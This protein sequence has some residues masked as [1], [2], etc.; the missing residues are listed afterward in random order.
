MNEKKFKFG[1]KVMWEGNIY[2][3]LGITGLASSKVVLLNA[4]HYNHG[5]KGLILF[6]LQ[7]DIKFVELKELKRG[8]KI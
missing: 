3:Y 5:F 1:D 8:W 6:D 4:K 7:E 2:F